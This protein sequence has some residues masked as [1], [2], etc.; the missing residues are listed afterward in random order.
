MSIFVFR[1]KEDNRINM[2]LGGTVT[3]EPKLSQKGDKLRFSVCYGKKKYMNCEVY[4]DSPLSGA[5]QCLEH[6]DCVAVMGTWREWEYNGKNYSSLSV[7]ALIPPAVVPA[8]SA[9]KEERGSAN[10]EAVPPGFTE[11][12]EE[13]GELPFD[14]RVRPPTQK[15]TEANT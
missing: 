3:Q 12:E 4:L 1:E 8:A 15:V 11:E 7:D 6:G 2:L 13:E 5:A 10:G 9:S 14:R